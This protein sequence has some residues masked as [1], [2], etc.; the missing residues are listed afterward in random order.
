MQYDIETI[1]ASVLRMFDEYIG[2]LSGICDKKPILMP[3]T[4]RGYWL[5]RLLYD[6]KEKYELGQIILQF[7]IYSDR[8]LTK[9]LD[10]S[11]LDGRD[12]LL[13]DDSLITGNNMFY[14]YTI[15]TRWGAKATPVVYKCLIENRNGIKSEPDC[16]DLK[17]YRFVDTCKVLDGDAFDLGTCRKD[18]IKYIREFN[19]ALVSINERY[20]TT[21]A[22]KTTLGMVEM[23]AFDREICPLVIDLPIIKEDNA[24]GKRVVRISAQQWERLIDTE[25]DGWRFVRNISDE[26]P[27][28]E[29]NG[30]FFC[31][32]ETIRKRIPHALAENCIIKCKY[33]YDEADT[34]RGVFVPF[35]IMKSIHY[36]QLI[37]CFVRLFDGSEYYECIIQYVQ[38]EYSEISDLREQMLHCIRKNIN[39]Y[40]TLYRAVVLYFSNYLGMEFVHYFSEK[41][42]AIALKYDVEFMKHHIPE[43]LKNTIMKSYE[44][45]LAEIQI[46]LSELPEYSGVETVPL[47]CDAGNKESASWSGV[48]Y[49]VKQMISDMKLLAEQPCILT[50]EQ[51]DETLSQ[52]FAFENDEQKRIYLTRCIT[53]FQEGSYFSNFLENNTQMGYVMRGF[54]PGEG[55]DFLL[56]AEA[57]CVVPYIYAYYIKEGREAYS[58]KYDRFVDALRMQLEKDGYF[59]YKISKYGFEYYINYFRCSGEILK[60]RLDSSLL[61]I[62]DYLEGCNRKYEK[63]ISLVNEW[64]L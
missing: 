48:Y 29:I 33:K 16:K 56:G 57:E 64:S 39:F 14:Y 11:D 21:H 32:P 60:S 47:T 50:I 3:I 49:A 10:G 9:I 42:A 44:E 4:R 15:L 8:Y 19:N 22:D 31:V 27:N 18:Y 55:S 2:N 7:E 6:N 1:F 13:F 34:V 38:R 63:E 36:E 30:S 40:R 43:K 52:K 28:M 23:I 58:D 51:M 35:T 12:V 37:D 54:A 17:W 25:N 45:G 61:F 53:L 41:I 5:F 62:K 46:K 24:D 20:Y 26:A 59:N